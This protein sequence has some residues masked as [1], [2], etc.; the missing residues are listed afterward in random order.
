MG[1]WLRPAFFVPGFWARLRLN[2]FTPRI[3]FNPPRIDRL[4][5]ASIWIE[6][7]FDR[8]AQ[9][10]EGVDRLR[11]QRPPV[12]NRIRPVGFNTREGVAPAIEFD[13]DQ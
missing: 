12:S 3:G 7:V 2:E 1:S 9:N 6:R 11:G 4:Q 5:F 10:T 8:K 13:F